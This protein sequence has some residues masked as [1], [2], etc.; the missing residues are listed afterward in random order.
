MY[1]F[2][3][4]M[5]ESNSDVDLNK[6]FT[7]VEALK[8]SFHKIAISNKVPMGPG[9]VGGSPCVEDL[10]FWY[11]VARTLKPKAVL[12]VGAWIGTSTLVIAKALNEVHGD[13]YTIVTCDYPNNVFITNHNYQHLSKNIYYNTVHSDMLI[14]QLKREGYKFDSVFSDACLS[15]SNIDDF[16]SICN[17][18]EFAFITHDVYC[19]KKSK[20]NSAVSKLLNRYSNLRSIVPDTEAGY[21][22][23]SIPNYTINAVTGVVLSEEIYESII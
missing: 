12:E 9:V 19:S 23:N 22:Y 18:N 11:L 20:G 7:E 5:I 17:I 21:V 13:D 6:K 15:N 16:N 8:N 14:P 10:L 1:S 4:K 3:K 2:I